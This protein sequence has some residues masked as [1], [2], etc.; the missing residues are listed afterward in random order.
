MHV[1]S[2]LAVDLIFVMVADCLQGLFV[3]F[4]HQLRGV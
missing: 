1:I 3:Y 4:R 2:V